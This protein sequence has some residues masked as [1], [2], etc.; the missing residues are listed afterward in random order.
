[1]KILDLGLQLV[2][3]QLENRQSGSDRQRHQP[4][5]LSHQRSVH[6]KSQRSR[7]RRSRSGR[8]S[9]CSHHHHLA[10]GPGD[11]LHQIDQQPPE[12]KPRLE[13][14]LVH[15]LRISNPESDQ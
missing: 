10:L 12:R 4:S 3:S 9:R 1:M 2:G 11:R 13:R 7:F 14:D 5:L 15:R 8:F 6:R